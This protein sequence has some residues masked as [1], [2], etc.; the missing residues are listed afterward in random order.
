MCAS[1]TTESHFRMRARADD[2][3]MSSARRLQLRVIIIIVRPCKWTNEPALKDLQT[4]PKDG[5]VVN[6]FS[7]YSGERDQ[8]WAH[9]AT[10]IEKHAKAKTAP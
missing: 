10:V 5:K 9:G 6:T 2:S 3:G 7:K 1:G 8:V 4:L